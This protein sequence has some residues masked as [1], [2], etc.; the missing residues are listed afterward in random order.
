MIQQAQLQ[1][2]VAHVVQLFHVSH[3]PPPQNNLHKLP[4]IRMDRDG[5]CCFFTS[6]TCI[7]NTTR[8]FYFLYTLTTP[9]VVSM[10]G[11]WT[12]KAQME[13]SERGPV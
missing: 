11:C 6:Y 3:V 5:K 1:T 12:S 10:T 2:L 4:E 9:R 7:W 8:F 13:C